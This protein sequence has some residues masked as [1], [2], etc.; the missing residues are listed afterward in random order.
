MAEDSRFLR[1]L[2]IEA[3]GT[4]EQ[5]DTGEGFDDAW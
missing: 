5:D 3:M 2:A 1:E 4:P